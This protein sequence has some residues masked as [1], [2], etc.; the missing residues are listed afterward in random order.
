[1]SQYVEI[2]VEK[3]VKET[4]HAFLFQIEGEEYWVP[5]SQLESE[6][7]LVEGEEDITVSMTHFIAEKKGLL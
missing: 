2:E 4:D 5:K 7:G 3:V 1:M 6:D